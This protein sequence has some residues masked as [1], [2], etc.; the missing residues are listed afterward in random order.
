[1]ACGF[2]HLELWESASSAFI[3][4]LFLQSESL[5]NLGLFAQLEPFGME[6]TLLVDPLKGMRPEIIALR[7]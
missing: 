2:D 4:V 1:M 6:P 3:R 7:L 5:K